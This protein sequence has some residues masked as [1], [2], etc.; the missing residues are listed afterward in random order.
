[1]EGIR[2]Q[3]AITGWVH[4][5]LSGE[6]C[7]RL[8]YTPLRSKPTLTLTLALVHIRQPD[9]G[10]GRRDV[11]R[12]NDGGEAMMALESMVVSAVDGRRLE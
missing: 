10:R 7:G 9:A 1:M 8:Y 6:H 11:H 4:L 12:D 2:I 5:R 3:E